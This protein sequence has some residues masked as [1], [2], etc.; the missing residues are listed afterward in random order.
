MKVASLLSGGKDSVLAL[1]VAWERGYEVT[2]AILVRP[3][4]ESPMFHVP[5]LHVVPLQARSMG[6]PLTEVE[7]EGEDGEAQ[8]E[9][10]GEALE[11][12]DVDALVTG[13][14]ASDYQRTRI[15]RVGHDH[16]VKT[17]SPLWHKSG[18]AI[19]EAVTGSSIVA[20][21]TAVSAD[22]FREGWLGRRITP[23]TIEHLEHLEEGFGVHV[24]G[25]GGEYE[26]TVVDAPLFRRKVMV[27]NA[28][29]EWESE[30]RGTWRI[31]HAE[32]GRERE[33]GVSP[34]GREIEA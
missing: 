18:R 26:T 29:P 22:G 1:H 11:D 17:F 15:E 25:E 5:N 32:L 23:Q 20:R 19:L 34:V 24:A 33:R 2:D 31:Q 12:L 16:G 21:V 13:A 8:A 7:A 3:P 4:E 27:K 6:I 10:V 14:V 9:A 28:V 30:H